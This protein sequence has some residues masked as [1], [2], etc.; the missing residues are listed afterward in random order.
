VDL[1]EKG[2]SKEESVAFAVMDRLRLDA[3][4]ASLSDKSRFGFSAILYHL[5]P[6]SG[7]LGQVDIA[8]NSV[9]LLLGIVVAG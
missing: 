9:G 4:F 2:E 5:A 7:H 6:V 1:L 3:P 8:G